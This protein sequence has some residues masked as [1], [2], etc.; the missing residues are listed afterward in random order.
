MA[1][2]TDLRRFTITTG[3]V[4]VANVLGVVN[5]DGRATYREYLS[6][7]IYSTEQVSSVADVAARYSGMVGYVLA[8]TDP[9]EPTYTSLTPT[10]GTSAGGTSVVITGTGYNSAA[11]VVTIGGNVATALTTRG[12]A[13]TISF[14]TPAHAAGAVN[15]VITTAEGTVTGT[16]AF[17]YT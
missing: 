11:C 4:P 1:F 13:T 8:Y 6:S 7:G 9:D 12:N 16:G 14:V 15:V 3:T 17:T 5:V 10:S 2:D